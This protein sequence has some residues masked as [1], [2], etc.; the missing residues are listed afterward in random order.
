MELGDTRLVDANLGANLL[1]RRLAVIVE[2]DHLLLARRQRRDGRAHALTRLCPLVRGVRL[3]GFR[4]NQGLG[5]RRFVE[6]LVVG[7]RGRRLNGVDANDGATEALFVGP[8]FRGQVGQRRLTAELAS[9][10]FASGLQL[11]ALTANATRPR[12]LA[13]RVDHGATDS[14]LGKCLKLD[15]AALVEPARCVDQTDDPVLDE[16]ADVNRVWHRRRDAA[17]ELLDEGDGCYNAW[18][19]F[20]GQGAH[21]VSSGRPLR[22]RG[23]QT[24]ESEMKHRAPTWNTCR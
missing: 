1:H 21:V 4:R 12:V 10:L 22:Q 18:V 9:Q 13:E 24:V 8:D 11:T 15:A 17:G 5:K 6:V 14:P 20:Y 2:T 3:F 19:L 23:Y 7:E 16:V